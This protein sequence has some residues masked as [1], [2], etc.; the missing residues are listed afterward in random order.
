MMQ[1]YFNELVKRL[2]AGLLVLAMIFPSGVT[3]V[4]AAETVD[5]G[6]DGIWTGWASCES[7]AEGGRSAGSD[8]GHAFGLFQFDDR[9]ESLFTFMAYCMSEDPTLYG[10]FDYY[11]KTYKNLQAPYIAG[12]SDLTGMI[13]TWHQAYDADPDKFISLQLD[14]YKQDY[15]APVLSMCSSKGIDLTSD[16]FSPV[17]RGTL[18]SIS[19]WA[20]PTSKGVGKVISRL[21]SGMTEEEMLDI[22]YSNSTAE[23]KGANSKYIAAFRKRWTDTQKTL[24]AN[25]YMKWKNGETIPTTESD[26]ISAMFGGAGMMYG[27]DGG[28]YIDYIREWMDKYQDITKDFRKGGW[29]TDNK[30]WAMALRN[31]GD[32]KEMYGILGNGVELDF[33]TGTTAGMTIS[34]VDVDAE[35]Y[36]VPDNGGNNPVVYFSQGG[37]QPWSALPFGGGNIASSGCS[38]TSL[39]MVVSYLTGGTD[40]ES[41]V[42]PS[43]IRAK[44]QEKTGNYNHFYAG[45]SGQSWGIFGAV[46]GYYGLH[47]SEISSASIVSALSAGK[48]V[49]MSCKPGEFTKKGHFI[50]LTGVTDDGYIVVN[51]PSHPDKSRL[52]YTAS[53][54]ASQGKGWW[55]FSN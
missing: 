40:K 8:G 9:S 52:K 37:G 47:C 46:A 28:S 21:S 51:D 7:G 25:A 35:N 38:I 32:F 10:G 15:Y 41:W 3:P 1:K 4:S 33:S 14:I 17:I 44:I 42:Y 2:L 43:D 55:A 11:Y 27:I 31:A 5:E 16:D 19:I 6:Q 30:E 29:N 49:I 45:D 48:P 23:M 13:N 12:S 54:I 18:W 53:Y 34:G 50:V 36:A 39:S 20:G 24:A 22:C 26:N